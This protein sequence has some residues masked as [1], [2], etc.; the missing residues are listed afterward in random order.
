[1]RYALRSDTVP[2]AASGLCVCGCLRPSC[3]LDDEL[4][5]LTCRIT[6]GLSALEFIEHRHKRCRFDTTYHYLIRRPVGQPQR[7]SE[8]SVLQPRSLALQST[9]AM[10]RSDASLLYCSWFRL[11]VN[12][13][14]VHT[15]ASIACRY[16]HRQ[17]RWSTFLHKNLELEW[18]LL[19]LKDVA[20]VLQVS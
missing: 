2:R 7:L 14:T 9:P 17:H 19:H 1:M 18:V 6:L 16:G 8:P 13:R 20:L 5:S 10:R 4:V 3:G 12:G 15:A 11:F